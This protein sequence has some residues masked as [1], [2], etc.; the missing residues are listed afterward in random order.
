MGL[1]K[2]C[3]IK[4]C[5]IMVKG[6][7]MPQFMYQEELEI[8]RETQDTMFVKYEHSNEIFEFDKKYIEKIIA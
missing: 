3:R 6:G 7:R 4:S 5:A 8:V 2:R 1:Q